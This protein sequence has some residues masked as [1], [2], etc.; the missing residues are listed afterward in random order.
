MRAAILFV[1]AGITYVALM[2][3]VLVAI[4][5][6]TTPTTVPELNGRTAAAERDRSRS[7]V[8]VSPAPQR[9]GVALPQPPVPPVTPTPTPDA[10]A[11]PHVVQGAVDEVIEQFRTN[12][13]WQI[14]P[15][16]DIWNR[17]QRLLTSQPGD[18]VQQFLTVPDVAPRGIAPPA[19]KEYPRLRLLTDGVHP[20][21]SPADDQQLQRTTVPLTSDTSTYQLTKSYLAQ[22]RLPEPDQV[23]VEDFLAALDYDFTPPTNGP[24]SV[25]AVAGPSHFGEPHTILLLVGIQAIAG[26]AAEEV[27]ER[28]SLD[29]RFDP[30][31]VARYRL[32][33]HEAD[34][35]G[36]LIAGRTVATIH[37][38]QTSVALFE[39]ELTGEATSQIAVVELKWIDPG[40]GASREIAQPV[41][42]LQIATTL[43]EA[44][45]PLQ[46]A[47]V[48]AE[49][50]EA[51]RA[52]PYSAPRGGSLEEIGDC[53]T[54]LHPKLQESPELR[55]MVAVAEAAARLRR[56]PGREVNA[57]IS[58]GK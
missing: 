42:R 44:A 35:L 49:T 53:V 31:S 23:R 2:A 43:L 34:L 58:S 3:I 32:L 40:D 25:H 12:E 24:L 6:D 37:A 48:A 45:L 56:S 8:P 14:E 26:D 10:G 21:V 7:A 51:L 15:A 36:G 27:A 5:R 54:R 4:F 46:M 19:V 50:A 41:S 28:A 30:N 57:E 16:T 38:G 33:G 11:R 17:S 9:E 1:S 29:V 18:D 47:T 55:E 13:Q 20:F 39:L 22:G 52:S